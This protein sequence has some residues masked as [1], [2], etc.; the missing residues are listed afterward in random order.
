MSIVS[1]LLLVCKTGC[2]CSF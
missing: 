2:S 1:T